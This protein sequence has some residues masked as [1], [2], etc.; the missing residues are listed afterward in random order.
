MGLKEHMDIKHRNASAKGNSGY[1]KFQIRKFKQIRGKFCY[2]PQ[3][4]EYLEVYIY[5]IY[6][7]TY[8]DHFLSE[9]L[10]YVK[11]LKYKISKYSVEMDGY[12]QQNTEYR[13]LRYYSILTGIFTSNFLQ[14]ILP[15][16]LLYHIV[17]QF[18]ILEKFYDPSRQTLEKSIGLFRLRPIIFPNQINVI[19]HIII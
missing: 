1:Q 13:V 6:S 12:N 16:S 11:S 3:N 7:T 4:T 17:T 10:V 5:G 14:L 2:N 15:L 18:S 8:T 9:R 19:F